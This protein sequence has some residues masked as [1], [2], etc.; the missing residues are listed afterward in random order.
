MSKVNFNKVFIWI[1]PVS[2]ISLIIIHFELLLKGVLKFFNTYPVLY[3]VY[4]ALLGDSLFKW[5]YILESILIVFAFGIIILF[6]IYT[7]VA[8]SFFVL[9]EDF[10]YYLKKQFAPGAVASCLFCCLMILT[11]FFDINLLLLW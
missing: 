5:F 1:I 2:T 10:D 4:M 9:I 7:I 3:T 11:G 8:W 6:P